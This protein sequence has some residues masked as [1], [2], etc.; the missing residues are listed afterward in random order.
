MLLR[1]AHMYALP[2]NCNCPLV[3]ERVSLALLS[4][5]VLED[6]FCGNT[7]G[8]KLTFCVGV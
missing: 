4:E 8:S 2:C 6:M 7:W 3:L 1:F 5:V